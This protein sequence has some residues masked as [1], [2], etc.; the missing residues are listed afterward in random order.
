MRLVGLTCF[1]AAVLAC[2]PAAAGCY[3][4]KL[5]IGKQVLYGSDAKDAVEAKY[6]LATGTF[7]IAGATKRKGMLQSFC[8]AATVVLYE[9]GQQPGANVPASDAP[10]NDGVCWL[11]V[12]V[13][14]VSGHCF[15]PNSK[16]INMQGQ[17]Y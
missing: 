9:N 15:R 17:V 5:I 6:D 3:G 4:Y 12:S 8:D 1:A 16:S 10:E 11:K 2:S 13:G 14:E 7:E